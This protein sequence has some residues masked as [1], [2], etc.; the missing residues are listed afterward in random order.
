[1][2]HKRNRFA[3]WKPAM[4]KQV[5]I[6]LI[7]SIMTDTGHMILDGTYFI[8]ENLVHHFKSTDSEIWQAISYLIRQGF[9]SGPHKYKPVKEHKL[10]FCGLNIEFDGEKWII[11]A[12]FRFY[13]NRRPR[14]GYSRKLF[15]FRKKTYGSKKTLIKEQQEVLFNGTVYQVNKNSD[16]FKE[17]VK[18]EQP[19]LCKRCNH[20]FNKSEKHQ[21]NECNLNLVQDTIDC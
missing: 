9:L 15:R 5:Q 3:A 8:K 21:R 18:E 16:L 6:Y 7:Q 12:V 11:P 13:P 4:H 19:I 1:M 2:L 14:M 20:V 10:T 17:L